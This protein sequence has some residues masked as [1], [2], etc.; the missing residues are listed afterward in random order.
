M[1]NGSWTSVRL[2]STASS[3]CTGRTGVVGMDVL[4]DLRV[5]VLG[6]LGGFLLVERLDSSSVSSTDNGFGGL[7][8]QSGSLERC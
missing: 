7:L 2:I 6:R 8:G 3:D 4:G 5:G 1:D